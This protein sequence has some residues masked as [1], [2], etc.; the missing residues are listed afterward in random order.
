MDP[1]T[2]RYQYLLSDKSLL[3]FHLQF[4]PLL[5]P[6]IP[7][8]SVFLHFSSLSLRSLSVRLSQ[9]VPSLPSQH[10]AVLPYKVSSSTSFTST[11]LPLFFN[12]HLLSLP[13]QLLLSF[14][15]PKPSTL[16]H[17][18]LNLHLLSFP[19]QLHSSSNFLLHFPHKP[20]RSFQPHSTFI[21]SFCPLN[22]VYVVQ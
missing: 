14:E 6:L 20:R 9:C 1:Q 3:M 22:K 16:L 7:L 5:Y 15:S 11:H 4:S 8:L 17:Y 19:S 12:H 21:I 2:L 13:L 18:L 10:G